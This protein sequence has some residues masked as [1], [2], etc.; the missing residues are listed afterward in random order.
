MAAYHSNHVIL[1]TLLFISHS[2]SV[3]ICL[4]FH[5]HLYTNE[6]TMTFLDQLV[7]QQSKGKSVFYP[8]SFL[9]NSNKAGEKKSCDNR[10]KTTDS[11]L[12]LCLIVSQ[13][14]C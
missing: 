8:S 12:I 6:G 13:E 4:F 10:T 9:T 11:L 5:S 14:V 2:I 7:N 3:Q 1:A